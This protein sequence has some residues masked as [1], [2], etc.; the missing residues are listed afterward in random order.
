VLFLAFPAVLALTTHGALFLAWR[1]DGSV[2][3]RA[4]R[5]APLLWIGVLALLP[6]LN[7]ATAA[8]NPDFFPHFARRP[9]AWLLALGW[10][11]ALAAVLALGGARR[12]RPLAAFVASCGFLAALLAATAA[13]AY[14]VMLRST[15]GSAFHLT[16][17]SAAAA[18]GSLRAGL[19]W[20]GLGIPLA[21][22]YTAVALRVHRRRTAPRGD[23][24]P[25]SPPG[26]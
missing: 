18:P 3:E 2:R 4:R 26:A 6:V 22:A 20:W 24:G 12:D 5:A 9:A 16:A 10:V 13:S 14:P 15:E 19:W 7:W 25:V 17:V 1:A 21:V 8:V 11:A 23:L